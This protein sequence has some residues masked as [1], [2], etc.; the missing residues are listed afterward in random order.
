MTDTYLQY[1]LKD[2]ILVRW[3][4]T[5]MPIRVYIAPFRW[6]E[7]SKQQESFVYRQ[8]VLDAMATWSRISGGRVRF[9]TVPRVQDS[10]IDLKWRRVDRKSLGHCEYLVDSQYRVYSAEIQIGISDGLVHAQYN[11]ADEVR[12]TIIHEFGHA[13]G[14]LGHSDGGSDIMYVP[15]QYGIVSVS[16]RDANTLHWLYKLPVGFDYM[17]AGRYFKLP[18][19]FGFQDVLIAFDA[20]EKGLDPATLF[21]PKEPTPAVLHNIPGLNTPGSKLP[22]KVSDSPQRQAPPRPV[23]KAE[24]LAEHHD[25]LSTFGRYHLATQNIQI[26]EEARQRFLKA[27]QRRPPN[28]R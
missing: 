15:H 2:G 18:E 19:P 3:A 23:A 14:L 22:A 6:Y 11:S 7:K 21:R 4:D 1:C 13:L 26:S 9:T 20:V 8:M 17:A 5:A 12:H 10:Q 25:I 27:Q 24:K 16:E 28:A